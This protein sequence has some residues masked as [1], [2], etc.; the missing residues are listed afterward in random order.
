LHG[1][2]EAFDLGNLGFKLCEWAGVVIFLCSL[3]VR[4][5]FLVDVGDLLLEGVDVVCFNFFPLVEVSEFVDSVFIS[6][7]VL[8]FGAC[9]SQVLCAEADMAGLGFSFGPVNLVVF[10]EFLLFVFKD[11]FFIFFIGKGYKSIADSFIF[12]SRVRDEACFSLNLFDVVLNVK[13]SGASGQVAQFKC[14][15]LSGD[16]FSIKVFSWVDSDTL[17]F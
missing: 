17:F 8:N 14:V 11:S 15:K 16:D 6:A 10:D 12:V 9:C 13:G 1:F 5:F 7:S 4:H 2:H 3:E